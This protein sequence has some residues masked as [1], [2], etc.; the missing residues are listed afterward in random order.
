[1]TPTNGERRPNWT[2]DG[3]QEVNQPLT[4]SLP[5]PPRMPAMLPRV[6]GAVRVDVSRV[7]DF[8]RTL[9]D[10]TADAPANTALVIVVN[11]RKAEPFTRDT[12][13]L[14]KF[15]DISFR[16]AGD[17][18]AWWAY[19]LHTALLRDAKEVSGAITPLPW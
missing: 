2:S 16:A 14:F 15:S 4:R 17:T 6:G 3:A 10:A 1:M 9:F 13:H 11:G 19:Y 12:R 7:I 18:I 5:Q 8:E